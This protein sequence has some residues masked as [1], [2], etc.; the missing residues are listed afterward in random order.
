M[1]PDDEIRR[2][3]G[4]AESDQVIAAVG[5]MA[6]QVTAYYVR[7]ARSNMPETLVYQLTLQ[8]NAFIWQGGCACE[9]DA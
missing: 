2:I 6:D 4:V 9:D 1:N 8:A 7:L 5:S 3:V